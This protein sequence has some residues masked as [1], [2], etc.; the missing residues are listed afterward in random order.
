MK[1]QKG[2]N[3]VCASGATLIEALD[4]ATSSTV[5]RVLTT[6]GIGSGP[7]QMQMKNTRSIVNAISASGEGLPTEKA[8]ADAVNW[9]EV[10]RFTARQSG[11]GNKYD[12]IALKNA[13]YKYARVRENYTG[14]YCGADIDL[15]KVTM[16]TQIKLIDR[17]SFWSSSRIDIVSITQHS[18]DVTTADFIFYKL[19][20]TIS[21][22]SASYKLKTSG[23]TETLIVEARK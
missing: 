11:S 23:E 10:G 13:G 5:E 22:T 18:A 9:I 1:T 2:L 17:A 4:N 8:V 3:V 16:S 21:G 12:F 19:S 15:S 6:F 20:I 14:G 7:K